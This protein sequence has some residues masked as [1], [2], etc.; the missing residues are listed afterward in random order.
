MMWRIRRRVLA[1]MWVLALVSGS[2]WAG[3]LPAF[4]AVKAQHVSSEA[5]LLD[6][7]GLVLAEVRMDPKIRRLDWVPV[8]HFSPALKAALIA[9]EDKRFYEHDG[10]DWQAFASAMWDNLGRTLEG[11]RP[12]GASTLSMQLVGLLDEALRLR[13]GARTLGQKWDQ[14]FEAREL[15]KRWTKA[16]I[17]EA[18]LNVVTFRGELAGIGAASRGLFGKN[19]DGLDGRE[20]AILVAL[21]RG[22]NAAPEIIGKRA[23]LVAIKVDNR[24]D[25]P[26][27]ADL[28]VS[29]L[30]G[31]YRIDQTNAAPHIARKLL[32]DPA[33]DVVTTLD[34]PLQRFAVQTLRRNLSEMAGRNVE[35]GAVL[36]LDNLSG[37]VLA[38]VGSSGE[39]SAA[40]EVDGV[41]APRQAGSTLKPFLYQ[42]AIEKRWLTAASIL[43]DSPVN[44]ATAGG[45]YVPQNYDRDFK[46][47]VSLRTA[48]GSSL[49]LPAVRTV[50]LVG[51][52]VFHERLRALG[53][54]TLTQDGDFYGYA[55]ALGSGDV[56]LAALT[57]A[58][59]ALANGGEWAAT[60]L[61]ESQPMPTKRR[62]M[63]RE[64]SFVIADV[65]ADPAA[66]SLTFGLD[67]ALTTRVWSAAKTGTSKDMRDNWCIGFTSRY[68]V[69]V[70][71]GNFSGA[72]MRDVSGVS[73]AAPIWRDIVQ[74]LHSDTQSFPPRPPQGTVS[75]MVRFEPP[76][77]PPRREWFL[78]GTE[79]E[80]VEAKPA[81]GTATPRIA[82]P[83]PGTVIALD[84]D[85]P[86]GRQR[87]VFSA[88]DGSGTLRWQLNG[89]RLPVEG[90]SA[91]WAPSSGNHHL[92]LQDRDG[93]TLDSV[94]FEVRGP[95]AAS[96]DAQKQGAE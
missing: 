58:F 66:R 11:R 94:H 62:V 90:S 42:L 80:L 45:L 14:A 79:L 23:C 65:L 30:S 84:P 8:Q 1:A 46:G 87:V 76:L 67:N 19:P 25:C 36:V 56:T 31:H 64:A 26:A 53:F 13:G 82:Y 15:E 83:A 20:A 85:I 96:Q 12:R 21:L 32:K 52:N 86:D 68:T 34:G 91:P 74:Y 71:V 6:R 28:A 63:R 43:D 73:G 4:E 57:N 93:Q 7:N 40:R 55:L 33:K 38:Y 92:V 22:P 50:G 70:W 17:L 27:I 61:L 18:Y 9:S 16:Q 89:I 2:V 35:D 77:E 3:A 44:L 5:R 54:D 24:G 95:L 60:R 81:S 29:S 72:P 48:L 69:G 75:R 88:R 47:P 10:V 59:R 37:D 51:V 41:T 49:N 78:A 39:L